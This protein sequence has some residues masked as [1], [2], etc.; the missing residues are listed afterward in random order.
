MIDTEVTGIVTGTG[1]YLPKRIL[2]NEDLYR[3]PGIKRNFDEDAAGKPFEPWA[4]GMTGI[5]QRHVYTDD[6]MQDPNYIGAVENM[7]AEAGKRALES[8]G[9]Q[10]KDL[11]H[12]ILASFTQDQTV[13]N[14]GC[15]AGHLIGADGI[16]ATHINNACAGFVYGII[17]AQKEIQTGAKNVLVVASEY[18]T[19]VTDYQDPKTAVLFADGAGAAVLS[20]EKIGIFKRFIFKKHRTGILGYSRA[21]DYEGDHIKLENKQGQ[22]NLVT[23]AGGDDVLKKAVR[24]MSEQTKNALIDANLNLDDIKYIVP[25]QANERIT[26]GLAKRLKIP[27]TKIVDTIENIGNTSGS[28]VAIALDKLVRGELTNYPLNKGDRILLTAVGV[29]YTM[30]AGV[31]RIGDIEKIRSRIAA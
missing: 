30:G 25:H 11:D 29:G 16:P 10:A 24:A 8:A 23:M 7:A 15:A 20:A 12:I 22:K 9:I 31:M 14:P 6:F 4:M 1:S 21:S 2:T 17:Q 27:L 26:K 13:P 5:S 19:K 3:K 18:L 28:S